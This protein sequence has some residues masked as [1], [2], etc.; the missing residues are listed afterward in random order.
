[1]GTIFCIASHKGGVGKTTT[2]INLA[3][4]LALAEKK[5]LLV[6][7]DPQGQAAAGLGISGRSHAVSLYQG[8]SHG[9]APDKLPAADLLGH[10]EVLPAGPSLAKAEATLAKK[11]GGTRQLGHLLENLTGR[12]DYIVIDAPPGI[13][14]LAVSA[15]MAAHS[16]LI[17]LQCEF[18]ALY[19]L[20]GMLRTIKTVRRQ[21]NPRLKLAG[22]L[23]TM[24]DRNDPVCRS[25][26]K[27]MD[28]RF[29]NGLCQ[30]VIP[31]QAEF[32][33]AAASKKPVVLTH[34]M[35]TG[36]QHYI[37]LARELMH[38]QC[39]KVA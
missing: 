1:M 38:G 19:G 26:V 37:S 32:A 15:L 11:Q 30:T 14:L 13:N 33:Q 24:V 10:L 4:A 35:S 21:F 16:V 17:P 31:R 6:D 2:A 28:K 29:G 20:A 27:A 18:Y 25:I 9:L 7:A 23:L 3:A 36:A 5:T 34:T 39:Q 22:V 8:L 12:F